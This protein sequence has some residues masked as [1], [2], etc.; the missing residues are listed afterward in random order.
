MFELGHG[1]IRSCQ[2]ISRRSL[3]TVG[4]LGWLGLSLPEAL[5]ATAPAPA[6]K[7]E[8]GEDR[9][10]IFIFLN[11]GPSQYETFDPKP[12]QPAEI[13]G[14]YGAIE[15]N[16]SGIRISELL[17]N[18]SR[19]MD[20]YCV[21]RGH[22]HS[23]DIHS[24]KHALTGN[25]NGGTAYGAVVSYLRGFKTSVPPYFR[26][27]NDMAGVSGGVLG[28]AFDP[29]K[30]PDPT[31]GKV[32]LPDF[33]LPAAVSAHRFGRRRTLLDLVD[34]WRRDVDADRVVADRDG[35]Y[36]RALGI[37]TSAEVSRAFSLDEEKPSLR[38]AYGANKFGQ[39][40]LLARRLVEA[41]ARFVEIKW[42]GDFAAE[43]S[44]YDAWDVH[45]AELPGLSRMETQLCPRFDHG[46]AALLADM[47]DRGLLENTLVVA[48]GEFGRTAKIN[49]WGGRDH[50]P[51][52]Q[53][54][55]LAGA[56]VPGGTIIGESDLQGAYPASRPVSLPDFIATLYRLLGLNA[57]LDDRLRPFAGAGEPMPELVG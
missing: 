40:C 33:D 27:G 3:L 43:S 4:T 13:R 31:S 29:V 19:Q 35:S 52:C 7:T 22:T 54:V 50:W 56:G 14:P 23:F 21:L 26:L 28:P 48:L 51:P 46:M 42:F 17:P 34:G 11:G 36:Q 47:H 25:P 41:G 10:C 44:A 20:K 5:A 8:G 39:S 53:S 9:N 30:V 6:P 45:G 38:D 32:V 2:G 57:N 12:D 16:V 18:L 1:R 24:A 49:K 55:L 15:T 37:L